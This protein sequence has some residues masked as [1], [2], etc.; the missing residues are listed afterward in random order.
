MHDGQMLFDSMTTWNHQTW[1]VDGVAGPLLKKKQLRD[2][3]VVGIW[4]IPSLRH[5]EYFPQRAFERMTA[6]EK[7]TVIAQLRR[8]NLPADFKPASD[9]YLKFLVSEL[10]PAIEQRFRVF[11]EPGHNFIAGSSMGGLISLYAL[12]EYPQVFGG[13]ACLSTHWPGSFTP[14]NNPIPNALFGYMR[15]H[16]PDPRSHKIYFDYGDQ[17]LDAL[18]PPLQKQADSVVAARGYS[19]TRW[20]TRFFPGKDHSEKAWNER[21]AIPLGF[22]L[23]R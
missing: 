3:I 9:N 20:Q 15:G 23:G 16:L 22:L 8:L 10:K 11:S 2:F 19:N 7:D 1:D 12:C 21:L 5:S 6:R 17:T 13:A 14:D 4:N 18:Y